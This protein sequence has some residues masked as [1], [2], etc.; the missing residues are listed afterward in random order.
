MIIVALLLALQ[1]DDLTVFK[2]EDQ[3]RKMLYGFLQAEC[4][5]AFDARRA[6]VAALKTP[7]DL[8]K[9]QELLRAKFIEALGGFPEKTP[10]NGRVVGTLK[11]DGFR[12]E[13]VIYESRPNHHV[14]AVLYLPEGKGPFP[15]VLV[16]CGHSDKGKAEE[17]YQRVS[18][19]LVRNGLAVLC[20]DPIGQGERMQLL[21]D[22]G[23]PAI[24]GNTTEHTMSGIGAL[25]VG[26]SCASFRIWDGIR[27]IDY[28]ESRP[29]IDAKRIGCTG[30]SG[31]GTLT[32]Y[33]MA[34]DERIAVAAPSCYVT[35]MERLLATIGPQDAEQN[36]TGQIAFG[37]EQTD[38][39]TMRA[40][41]PTLICTGT[42]D[43]FDI[44]GS[45]TTFREAKQLYGMI[46]HAERVDL[47][48]YNDKHGF[49]RPRREAATRWMRR[50]LLGID[51]AIVEADFP[52]F[53]EEELRCTKTGQVLSD[54]KGKSVFDLDIERENDLAAKR[55]GRSKDQ[56]V[57]LVRG[58]L[59]L[60]KQ[61]V[62]AEALPSSGRINRG[63]Y[64][65]GKGVL[66]VAG[67]FRLPYVLMSGGPSTRSRVLAISGDGK[68]LLT[69]AGGPFEKRVNDGHPVVA[70]DLRGMGETAPEG[71]SPFGA[72]VKEA[73]LGIL[74]NRPL[75]G[76]RVGDVLSVNEGMGGECILAASGAAVPVALHAAALDPRIP[77]LR[78][79]KGI[80]SWSSVVKARVTAN[81]F[82]NVVPGALQ[83]YDLPD[84]AALMAPRKL[85]ILDPVDPAGKPIS[86]AELEA[87]YAKVRDAY[88]AAGAEQNL[89]L[90]A[91]PETTK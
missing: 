85:T 65:V 6:A 70:L 21:N 23:K 28:L 86:Q 3:P 55:G 84:L 33:L 79:E 68:A 78:L 63:D 77:E 64:E 44:Q 15:G 69:A 90:K 91:A 18:Q 46:G 12:V 51:D 54:L 42:Q 47:I 74:L 41:K 25:L 71:K 5:K 40:P 89:V 36:I 2:P 49:S 30:N 14:S 60:P 43:F 73:F 66:T 34:I 61:I 59:R 7:E 17:A 35:T 45:W 32:S 62:A 80:L 20:Y 26:W 31:G 58:A 50:W 11:G 56:L 67:G 10:L 72:D 13:K 57:E 88:K 38:Y 27:S 16:P 53:K 48:E 83:A 87:A 8:K 75:L 24:K 39:V 76:Q 4:G 37:M 22:D 1:S 82:A 19:L 9:R 29:E 81:Q 52:V